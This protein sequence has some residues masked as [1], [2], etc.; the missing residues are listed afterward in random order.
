M[1]PSPVITRLVNPVPAPFVADCTKFAPTSRS[2][3]FVVVTEPLS[4]VAVVVPCAPADTSNG[5]F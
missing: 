1:S 3:A 4:L 5:L 2:F